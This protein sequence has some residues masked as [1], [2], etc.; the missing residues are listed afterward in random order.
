MLKYH[1][2][3]S[4]ELA[5]LRASEF[6]TAPNFEPI[7]RFIPHRKIFCHSDG[8]SLYISVFDS[9]LHQAVWYTGMDRKYILR[10]KLYNRR[11]S[12]IYFWLASVVRITSHTWVQYR[13][14]NYRCLNITVIVG[15][16]GPSLMTATAGRWRSTWSHGWR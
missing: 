13:N 14:L 2:E 12:I 8:V 1:T 6:V 9:M 15:R 5:S 10:N 4:Y 16:S 7:G 3:F 11:G